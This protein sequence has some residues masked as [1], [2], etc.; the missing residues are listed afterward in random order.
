MDTAVVPH[1]AK[2]C[3]CATTHELA[4]DDDR[5][6]RTRGR[7]FLVDEH[8]LVAEG[9]QLALRSRGYVVDKTGGPTVSD[10]LDQADAFRSDCVL[11][12]ID[13]RRGIG[14]GITLIGRLAARGTKVIVLTA[15]RRRSILA[16]CIEAGAVGWIERSAELDE[17]DAVL[18]RVVAGETVLG[19]TVRAELLDGLRRE[20]ARRTEG[21]QVFD[22]LTQREALVLA[23][24]TDGLSA[25]QIASEHFV[26]LSTVRSQIR[27]ILRKLDV[28]SQLAA[29]ALA[30]NHRDLLP[31][32]EGVERERRRGVAADR[33]G[34]GAADAAKIA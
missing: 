17:V 16:E 8:P 7:V 34:R 28:R 33:N 25:E 5:S 1:R 10:V 11:T 26:A 31:Q 15:E 24:L 20:R 9:L 27:A 6:S 2:D 3:G 19:A 30:S 14:C 12:D 32:R 22:D 13:F 29:A 18:S 23:A 21:S 4:A